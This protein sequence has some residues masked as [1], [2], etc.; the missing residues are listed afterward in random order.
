MDATFL[1][2]CTACGKQKEYPS[3]WL[4]QGE[5]TSCGCS[6]ISAPV[7]LTNK[8]F[9]H[10]VALRPTGKR[11]SRAVLW[12]CIC[13]CKK[14]TYR[15]HASLIKSGD[16]AS[17]GC[18]QSEIKTDTILKVHKEI[19]LYTENTA[20]KKLESKTVYVSNKSGVPGV[21]YNK[22]KN[23]WQASIG[24]KGKSIRLGNFS[25][26]EDAIKARLNAEDEIW[27]PFL[28]KYYERQKNGNL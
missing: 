27:K 21:F 28:E 16:N 24:F 9:G 14:T 4:L 6:R 20:I 7:D 17:C 15:T 5:V 22:D 2:E 25:E 11:S 12:E 8:R 1:C 26:K 23:K 19:M 10:L 3:G 13:D 18:V